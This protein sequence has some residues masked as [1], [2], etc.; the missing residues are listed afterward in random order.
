MTNLSIFGHTRVD[1]IL[2]KFIG[3][4]STKKLKVSPRKGSPRLLGGRVVFAL[5]FKFFCQ[6]YQVTTPITIP[7]AKPR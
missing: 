4:I 1:K 2:H 5:S 7:T 3:F 6:E